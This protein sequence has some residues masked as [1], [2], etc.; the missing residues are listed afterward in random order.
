MLSDACLVVEVLE[1]AAK[2]EILKWFTNKQMEA[3]K[4]PVI[5]G[6]FSYTF[7][8]LVL[9]R[10]QAVFSPG[11]E[12]GTL[13]QTE[14]RYAWLRRELRNYADNFAGVFLGLIHVPC[15]RRFPTS[16]C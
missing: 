5:F 9:M 10:I 1:K 8:Q 15:L 12:G 16:C 6:C 13:A 7:S 3:Y 14:R 2:T 11:E 4:V